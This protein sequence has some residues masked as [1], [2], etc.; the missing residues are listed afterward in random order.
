MD[1]VKWYIKQI[2][3]LMYKTTYG[4]DGKKYFCVWRMWLGRC[5][6][7]EEHEIVS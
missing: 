4:K 6:Q 5:F 1:K 2:F 7:I 3:P